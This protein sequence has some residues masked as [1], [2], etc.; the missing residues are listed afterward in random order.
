[1]AS[2]LRLETEEDLE[3]CFRFFEYIG[4]DDTAASA[5]SATSLLTALRDVRETPLDVRVQGP[6]GVGKSTFLAA[7]LV[8][9]R[10]ESP[11]EENLEVYY[12]D[13]SKF[14]GLRSAQ[15]E[16]GKLLHDL[17]NLQSLAHQN[18][19]VMIVD[20]LGPRNLAE[21]HEIT[22]SF[23]AR[24]DPTKARAVVW[25][26]AD[27]YEHQLTSL[28]T[29]T[30][31]LKESDRR[32]I[33]LVPF[34]RKLGPDRLRLY[35][36][37]LQWLW[38][39]LRGKDQP[40]A[41]QD[42][43]QLEEA[44]EEL[45]VGPTIDMHLASIIYG[46]L[47]DNRYQ[48][49]KNIAIFL[50]NYCLDRLK[51]DPRKDGKI[52][53][54]LRVASWLAFRLVARSFFS[55][56]TPPPL[57]INTRERTTSEWNL[58]NEHGNVR[59]FLCALAVCDLIGD[60]D[61][62]AA[63]AKL[64]EDGFL[65]FDFPRVVNRFIVALVQSG[66]GRSRK[67]FADRARSV[68]NAIDDS[69]HRKGKRRFRARNFL[70]YLLGRI[71][72]SCVLRLNNSFAEVEAEIIRR[73][74]NQ[75]QR[76]YLKTTRRT[77][78]VSL[79]HR[80]P[81]T[82]TAECKGFFSSLLHDNESSSIDRA[83]HLLY[84]GD[85]VASVDGTSSQYLDTDP[86]A[87]GNSFDAIRSFLEDEGPMA[88]TSAESIPDVLMRLDVQ[89]R[90]FTL[91]SFI[92]SRAT[93]G[94]VTSAQRHFTT[95]L[96]TRILPHRDVF[97]EGL[98]DYLQMVHLDLGRDMPTK[99]G[100]IFDL[101]RLKFEPRR[102]YLIRRVADSFN[103]GRI[104]SVAEHSYLAMVLAMLLL[105]LD[106]EVPQGEVDIG[107][108]SR[109]T[110][111]R[112]VAFHDIGEAF[113]GDFVTWRLS[114]SDR[115]RAVALEESSMRYVRFKDTYDGIRGSQEIFQTWREFSKADEYSAASPARKR[116]LFNAAVARDIDRLE[117]LIQLVV[118]RKIYPDSIGE[119]EY[120]EFARSL[121]PLT[122]VGKTLMDSL[123]E[124][125]KR[126]EELEWFEQFRDTTLLPR[127]D[128]IKT[129][130][131]DAC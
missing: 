25:G 72:E 12:V 61:N 9:L 103:M 42:T 32:V 24:F 69:P 15:Q 120:E 100:F 66:S 93:S 84:Y 55:G 115:D 74:K 117:N 68:L 112:M 90:I 99:W 18:S 79:I 122:V 51:T 4:Y 53:A 86:S 118:Y 50:K 78:C 96:L 17:E 3:T 101:Y 52:P 48:N 60:C 85:R 59:D 54:K 81:T 63:S 108:Y 62:K 83:Y 124:W 127:E 36:Q 67:L 19:L 39:R 107:N 80:S 2:E 82:Q 95:S 20:Q 106:D 73:L 77:I 41:S 47:D 37:H 27:G 1:M 70:F 89:H 29:E 57:K 109:E 116:K 45:D 64:V 123:R 7:L 46:H 126:Q 30:G 56:N 111:I 98:A 102:G 121:I 131:S 87:W 6:Q 58:V 71:D 22:K 97:V 129:R 92:Q 21:A 28:I 130:R 14:V 43:R 104:E 110:I 113:T 26:V 65:D 94:F 10:K 34:R 5:M 35:L 33:R 31:K 105:P 44:I 16:G 125:A 38:H 114:Q 91:C 8:A 75:D 76:L 49:S 88:E 119:T 23:L 13:A 40:L 128:L 11:E